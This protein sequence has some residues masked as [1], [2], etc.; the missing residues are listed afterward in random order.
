MDDARKQATTRSIG[1]DERISSIYTSTSTIILFLRLFVLPLCWFA[2]LPKNRCSRSQWVS[3]SSR[4]QQQPP[5]QE[6]PS[7]KR[8]A[9]LQYDNM[10][11]TWTVPIYVRYDT[12]LTSPSSQANLESRWSLSS[13][14]SLPQHTEDGERLLPHEPSSLQKP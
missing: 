7:K 14:S 2:G 10:W 5:Q 4:H 1:K 11:H 6:L 3:E 12:T 8:L 9:L 13:P